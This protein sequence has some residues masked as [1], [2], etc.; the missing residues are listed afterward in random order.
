MNFNQAFSSSIGRKLIMSITGISLVLF[1]IV[2]SSVNGMIFFNDN[3]ETFNKYA[4]F[5][6]HNILMRLAEVGLFGGLIIHIFQG[7][8]LTLSNNKKRN[9]KYAV[10]AGNATSKWYSRSMGVLGSLL[11]IFLVIHLSDFWWGTKVALYGNG[12]DA[13]HNLF[14]EMKTEFSSPLVVLIY[15][16]GV[17]SLFWHLAH[18][19]SSAF[20]TLGINNPKYNKII[21]TIGWVYSIIVCCAFLLMPLSF[22]F[23]WIS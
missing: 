7:L 15:C 21:K 17:I 14:Q 23:N 18:G 2:H 5:L 10:N 6:S 20:Q 8:S 22:Y 19:F 12:N 11:L 1:L 4:H 3:G 16:L 9:V 13:T